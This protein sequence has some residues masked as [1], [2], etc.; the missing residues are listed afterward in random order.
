MNMIVVKVELHSAITGKITEI[1]RMLIAND[2]TGS[3]RLGQYHVRLLKRG[4]DP[5]KM[6]VSKT[7][8]VL[9]HARLSRPVWDLV[10]RAINVLGFKTT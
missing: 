1:G 10:G 6:N 8:Y 2:G 3:H 9:N 7:G 5:E 4:S